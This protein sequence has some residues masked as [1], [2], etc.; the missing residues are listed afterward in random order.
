MLRRG[1]WTSA[2][3]ILTMAMSASGCTVTVPRMDVTHADQI[4]K[5]CLRPWR[6]DSVGQRW[7]LPWGAERYEEGRCF[8]ADV[9]ARRT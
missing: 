6:F 7:L 1:V 8:H 9:A 5:M 2:L 3:L 4:P